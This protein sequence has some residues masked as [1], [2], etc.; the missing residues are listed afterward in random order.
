[1]ASWAN[2]MKAAALSGALA[3]LNGGQFRL[4]TSG[5]S[6]LANLT[7]NSPAFGTATTASP[8]VATSNTIA[9]DSTITAG[10]IALFELR[11][12]GGATRI[13]GSVGVGTGDIQVA[14]VTIPPTATS[15]S[16]PGGLTISLQIS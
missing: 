12:S 1:M 13:S 8:S 6:E 14:S 3:L 7:L 10:D 11:T 5:S 9:A 15:V 16:C 4:L 2:E